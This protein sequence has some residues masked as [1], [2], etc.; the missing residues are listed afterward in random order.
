[1]RASRCLA[2]AALVLAAVGGGTHAAP[3]APSGRTS[4][5]PAVNEVLVVTS[6]LREGFNE[7]DVRN[8]KEVRVFVGRVLEQV[9][10]PPDALL[11]QEVRSKSAHYVAKVLTRRTQDRYRVAVDAARNPWRKKGGHVIKAD[12]AIVMN[13]TTMTKS[14]SSGYVTTVWD[15]VGRPPEH[16]KNARIQLGER[17]SSMRV[18]LASVHIPKASAP[19]ASRKLA[20]EMR[21]IYSSDSREHFRVLGGDFN[22]NSFHDGKP[23]SFWK[24]LTKRYG[25][26]DS[27][28]AFKRQKGVDF[29]FSW[30][31]A[32]GAGWDSRYRQGR[33]RFYSDHAFRWAKIGADY[34]APTAPSGLDAKAWDDFAKVRLDWTGS[35]DGSGTGVVGYDLYRSRDGQDFSRVKTFTE[36][37]P[38]WDKTTKRNRRYHYFVRARDYVGN[39]SERS[40]EVS[41][42]AGTN[43]T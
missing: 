7:R 1:V 33:D 23:T 34:E 25:Y 13:A 16:K 6:N 39:R 41:I 29:I 2:S 42:T 20:K 32:L 24:V 40:N 14:G 37:P 3:L 38:V 5:D 22:Q 35:T 26:L 8:M 21:R 31:T 4:A 15:P 11:L 27:L 36:P 18:S 30:R 12:T 43:D 9:P 17:A 19:S 28:W 10:Y